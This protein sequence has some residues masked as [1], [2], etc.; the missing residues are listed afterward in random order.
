[1]PAAT[2]TRCSTSPT[3]FTTGAS[4]GKYVPRP[5]LFYLEPDVIGAL[6]SQLGELARSDNF[7]N[8]NAGAGDNWAKAHNTKARQEFCDPPPGSVAAFVVNSEP[9]AGARPSVRVWG[10]RFLAVLIVNKS[11]ANSALTSPCGTESHKIS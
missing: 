1:V 5:V 11:Y 8:E 9:H 4:G 6:P 3:C 10:P 2:A 7:V